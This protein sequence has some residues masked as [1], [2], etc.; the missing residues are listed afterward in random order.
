M[1]VARAGLMEKF[2]LARWNRVWMASAI[3][4]LLLG[5]PA[6]AQT[7]GGWVDP[8]ADLSAPQASL[9]EVKR[10][11]IVETNPTQSVLASVPEGAARPTEEPKPISRAVQLM[12]EDPSA[13]FASLQQAMRHWNLPPPT[14][15]MSEA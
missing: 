11:P 2:M 10:P 6:L 13:E 15:A 7:T 1:L 9:S 14:V 8:P 4:A 3:P 5:S 12:P